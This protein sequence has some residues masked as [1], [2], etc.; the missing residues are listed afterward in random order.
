M[1]AQSSPTRR[2]LVFTD[3]RLGPLQVAEVDGEDTTRAGAHAANAT[4]AR[5]IAPA[6]GR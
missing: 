1:I 3:A 4:S 6:L 5:S 2:T